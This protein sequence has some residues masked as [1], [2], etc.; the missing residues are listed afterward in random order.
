MSN[1]ES[2]TPAR[3]K[4]RRDILPNRFIVPILFLHTITVRISP[5]AG[6][7]LPGS[8]PRLVQHD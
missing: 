2:N 3:S 1:R 7:E 5:F 4:T 8:I 6:R